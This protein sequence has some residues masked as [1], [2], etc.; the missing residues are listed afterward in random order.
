LTAPIDRDLILTA[1]FKYVQQTYTLTTNVY[2]SGSGYVSRHP[3]KETYAAGEEVDLRAL[4][5]SGY[6]FAGWSG[7]PNDLR[8]N[9]V[10][11]M[12]EDKTVT[13]NFY[14]KSITTYNVPQSEEYR[15]KK[16]HVTAI[17][18]D[19]IGAG[20]FVYGF[21]RNSHVKDNVDGGF[22]DAAENAVKQRNI[23]YIAGTILLL[24]GI[25][26]HIFF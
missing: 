8:P 1:N 26:V 6:A 18:L 10:I 15:A 2:P 23:G 11:R 13:A 7:V 4:A 17:S 3:Y 5:Y 14:K 24:S 9:T 19:V 20:L 21:N 12:I 25:T 22:Y 16:H